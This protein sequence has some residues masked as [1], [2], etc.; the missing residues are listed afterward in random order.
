VILYGF[1]PQL[2]MLKSFSRRMPTRYADPYLFRT[3]LSHNDFNIEDVPGTNSWTRLYL[4]S[5]V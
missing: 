3:K 1:G 4:S 2:R 5:T